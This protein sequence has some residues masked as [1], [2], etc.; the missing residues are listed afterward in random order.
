MANPLF[1]P[2]L[3]QYLQD[4]DEVGMRDF[5]EN[6]HPATIAETLQGDFTIADAWRVLEHAPIK[7]QAA[8]FEYFDR[9][10]QVAMVEGTG[11]ERMAKLIEQVSHDDRVDL[12]RRLASDVAEGL[13]RLVDEADRR[14]IA[15]LVSYLENTVGSMMTTDY[16]WLPETITAEVAIDRLRQ[17]A[18]DRET[19]YYV[20]VLEEGTRRLR[21]M[22]SLRDL[23]LARKSATL[24][25]LM[26]TNLITLKA[27][28]NREDAARQLARFDLIA[29]PVV[30]DDR[31]LVGIVTYDDAIDVVEQEATEDLQRQAAVGPMT[32]N[33][34]EASFL[35]I[36]RKR[37]FWLSCLFGAEL[38]T[39]TALSSFEDE[40][41]KLV[42]LSLFIP[43]CLS[44]G[45]N[46][47]SQAATLIT[48]SLALG[49]LSVGDWFRVLRHELAMGIVLGL[50]LGAIGLVRGAATPEHTR[51][52]TRERPEPFLL[53]TSKDTVLIE[54]SD[55]RI[56]LPKGSAQ[57]IETE[58]ELET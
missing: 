54:L 2:I 17:Q 40:I 39:F 1:G 49:H 48:R 35:K 5:C 41:S 14:D 25:E 29:M 6:L 51:S 38:F 58:T 30:D 13:L 37:A 11:R 3:R 33:Y 47:G 45:G 32:E 20:Y 22:L 55:G 44:T 16:A 52:A 26:D 28:D 31:R 19:I 23:I 42:V 7:E 15:T 24:R 8:V 46:S 27:N 4:N 9:D 50:T 18:P 12:V 34:L 21:G 43:L 36:W 10:M 56:V 53:R 57:L